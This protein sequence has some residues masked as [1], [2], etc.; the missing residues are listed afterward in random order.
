[1]V[2]MGMI[3][4]AMVVMGMI[5]MAMVVMVGFVPVVVRLEGTALAHGQQRHARRVAE[6]HHGRIGA[7]GLDRLLQERLQIAADPEDDVGLLQHG[8][9]RGAQG[10]GVGRQAARHDQLRFADPVHDAG[11]QGMERTDGYDNGWRLVSQSQRG[12]SRQ[13]R[14]QG[15]RRD[16]AVVKGSRH[17][18]GSLRGCAATR[19]ALGVIL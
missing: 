12:R 13:G 3:V 6:R 17:G 15:S 1:M 10:I 16:K 8:G 11:H 4:V 7:Q 19:R 14:C 2:V 9:I 18:L 5:V